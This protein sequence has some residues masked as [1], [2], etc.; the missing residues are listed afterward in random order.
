MLKC[1]LEF[2]ALRSDSSDLHDRLSGNSASILNASGDINDVQTKAICRRR[3]ILLGMNKSIS[4]GQEWQMEIELLDATS[5]L[6]RF[7]T[8]DEVRAALSLLPDFVMDKIKDSFWEVPS[9][10][11]GYQLIEINEEGKE[12][13]LYEKLNSLSN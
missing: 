6:D 4:I 11:G 2:A 12:L 13:T 3:W 8:G 1:G 7:A 9:D 10:C 5:G